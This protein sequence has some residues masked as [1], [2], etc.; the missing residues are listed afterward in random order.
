MGLRE[1]RAKLRPDIERLIAVYEEGNS[2]AQLVACFKVHNATVLT[3]LE[4]NG[5]PRGPTDPKR[6]D[7]DVVDAVDLYRDELSLPAIEHRLR[8][9]P[10]TV[11]KAVGSGRADSPETRLGERLSTESPRLGLSDAE[12]R[13]GRSRAMGEQK[14]SG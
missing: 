4:R 5:V 9:D 13:W 10:C 11:G 14:D 1:S 2:L 7:E 3:H 8:V 6:S 12:T